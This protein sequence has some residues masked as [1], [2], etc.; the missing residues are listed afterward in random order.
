MNVNCSLNR[1]AP[2]NEMP[3]DFVFT[4]FRF[5]GNSAIRTKTR[6][7]LCPPALADIDFFNLYAVNSE[8]ADVVGIDPLLLV[9]VAAVVLTE[10]AINVALD[11]GTRATFAAAEAV[12]GDGVL[13]IATLPLPAVPCAVATVRLLFALSVLFADKSIPVPSDIE[14]ERPRTGYSVNSVV[15]IIVMINFFDGGSYV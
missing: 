3:F 1:T 7:A 2:S 6:G 12:N 13:R 10:G 11:D 5:N 14:P 9:L 8:F 4:L 15:S